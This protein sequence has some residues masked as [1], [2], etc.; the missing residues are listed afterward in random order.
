LFTRYAVF[1]GLDQALA[2]IQTFKF[3][4]SDI[5]YLKTCKSLVDCDEVIVVAVCGC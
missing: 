4:A 5:A 3:T 2:F 1:A